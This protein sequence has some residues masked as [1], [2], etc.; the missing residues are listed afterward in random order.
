MAFSDYVKYFFTYSEAG[1]S[2]TPE[3]FIRVFTKRP[4]TCL[5]AS[6]YVVPV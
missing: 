2:L 6:A 4:Q 1:N 3:L 5:E